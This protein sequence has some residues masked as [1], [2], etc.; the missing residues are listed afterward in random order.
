MRNIN[1]GVERGEAILDRNKRLSIST[2]ELEEFFDEYKEN[3]N[4]CG[5]SGSLLIAIDKAYK[6]GLATGYSAAKRGR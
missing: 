4:D 6:W 5:M 3:L 1:R 2:S